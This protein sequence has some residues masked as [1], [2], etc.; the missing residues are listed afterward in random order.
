MQTFP[1]KKQQWIKKGIF[2]I[3]VMVVSF[4]CLHSQNGT[5]TDQ[6]Y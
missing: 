1:K 4:F 6:K 3:K 2:G 5:L